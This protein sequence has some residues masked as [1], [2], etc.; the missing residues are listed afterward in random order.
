MDQQSNQTPVPPAVSDPS[1]PGASTADT[2]PATWP[3]AFGAFK[4]SRNAMRPILWPYV[5][6]VLLSLVASGAFAQ[7]DSER[8]PIAY[9]VG[10]VINIVLSIILSVAMTLL[11]LN[12]L[13]GTKMSLTES[14]QQSTPYMLRYFAL[15]LVIGVIVI[16]SLLALVIPFFFVMPRL[17]LAEYFL[18]D[19]NMGVTDA[20]KA[21]WDQTKGHSG[22]VWGIIGAMI[23]M[24]LLIFVLV[25]IALLVLYSAAFGVL[26]MYITRQVTRRVD[27][28]TG[29]VAPV[30]PAGPH[31]PSA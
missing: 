17:V 28:S 16:A 3:G 15:N 4:Y 9:G 2:V 30:A 22:K 27:T 10:Y 6:L 1:T 11:V 5:G 24:A 8:N 31:A 18:L 29:P 12:G 13:R 20:L 23:V 7:L 26:Y 14:L 21:S 19:K 25:G